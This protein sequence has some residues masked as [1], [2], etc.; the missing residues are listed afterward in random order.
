MQLDP[1][2]RV[3]GALV[4]P[5]IDWLGQLAAERRVGID[6]LRARLDAGRA[7]IL[8]NPPG[9]NAWV[10]LPA[11]HA[12]VE[13][14]LAVHGGRADGVLHELGRRTVALSH[15][16]GKLRRAGLAHQLGDLLHVGQWRPVRA[17]LP[18]DLVELQSERPLAPV[19]LEWMARLLGRALDPAQLMRIDVHPR[20]E[21]PSRVVFVRCA[22]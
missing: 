15:D 2:P 22:V 14:L 8:L 12:L 10:S 9:P 5:I 17:G 13:V 16:L 19:L 11:T 18:G 6:R 4:A 7:D 3:R 20:R 21:G 1:S